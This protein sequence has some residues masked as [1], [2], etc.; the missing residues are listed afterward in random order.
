MA[1]RDQATSP[2]PYEEDDEDLVLSGTQPAAQRKWGKTDG[3]QATSTN[4]TATGTQTAP[5]DEVVVEVGAEEREGLGEE[6]EE[7]EMQGV[8]EE[9]GG[10]SVGVQVEQGAEGTIRAAER[11]GGKATWWRGIALGKGRGGDEW[12][13]KKVAFKEARKER[14]KKWAALRAG[15]V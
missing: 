5:R 14:K 1:A 13:G 15:N 8:E 4:A 9:G 12:E 7:E 11:R 10:R 3:G 2:A 6:E